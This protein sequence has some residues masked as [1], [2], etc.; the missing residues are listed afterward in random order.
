MPRSSSLR[1]VQEGVHDAAKKDFATVCFCAYAKSPISGMKVECCL[2][3]MYWGVTSRPAV[4][5]LKDK[6]ILN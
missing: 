1:P 5:K 4:A 3:C 2:K 6:D